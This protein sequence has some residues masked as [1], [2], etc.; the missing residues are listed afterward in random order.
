MRF[1]Q[2]LRPLASYAIV[3]FVTLAALEII[4]RVAD[5][6]ELRAERRLIDLG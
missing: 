6:R 1:R 2:S 5:F 3:T 4:L